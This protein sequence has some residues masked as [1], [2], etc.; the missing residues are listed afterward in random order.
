MMKK[1]SMLF[2]LLGTQLVFSQVSTK[3]KTPEQPN[4]LES[5]VSP[6][7]ET[8]IPAEFPGGMT[9]LR[10][11]ISSEFDHSRLNASGK[12]KSVTKF[13]IHPDGSMSSISTTGD[14]PSMNK[15]MTRVIKRIKTKWKPAMRNGQPIKTWYEIPMSI[16][17]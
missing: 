15:E 14:E 7:L 13:L 12:L 11:H 1:I 10:R 2:L 16:S 6:L 5:V 8:D 3:E 9:A 17:I 4:A